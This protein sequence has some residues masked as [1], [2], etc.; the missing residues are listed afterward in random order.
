M[1]A[2]T[3]GTNNRRS[4]TPEMEQT[5]AGMRGSVPCPRP[6]DPLE[7]EDHRDNAPPDSTAMPPG[8]ARSDSEG[9]K[10][11]LR[12]RPLQTLGLRDF[13]LPVPVALEPRNPHIQG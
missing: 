5:S 12:E 9:K 2:E 7:V 1:H 3:G 6:T 4:R 8:K 11:N 10:P 13:G